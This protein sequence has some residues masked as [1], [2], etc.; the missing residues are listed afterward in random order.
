MGGMSSGEGLV[1]HVRDPIERQEPIR[2]GR[3]LTGEFEA[4]VADPGVDDK[5]LLAYDPEFA[6]VLKVMLRDTNILS[7]QIRQAWDSG[8]LRTLTKNNPVVATGAHISILGHITKDELLRHLTET[9]AA[10]GFGNRIQWTCSKRS[11]VLPRGGGTPKID[12]LVKPLHDALVKA[13]DI[14]EITWDKEAGALWDEIYEQ[15]SSPQPR[16]FGAI[17]ARAEAQVLRLSV[18]YA[19]ID[20][21]EVIQLPHLLAALAVWDYAEASA[22]YIFGDATG[23]YIADRVLNTLKQTPEGLSRT[24]ISNLLGRNIREDRISRAL[25]LLLK[26]GRVRFETQLTE[27]RAKEVWYAT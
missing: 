3:R 8:T 11:K 21:S 22:R 4:V 2:D 23:D 13:R 14:G 18:I 5:R 17:T 20:G 15:L 19:A 12:Q 9:E 26:L 10:N 27:G 24:Q 6:S 25:G 1:Y 7:T 16:L